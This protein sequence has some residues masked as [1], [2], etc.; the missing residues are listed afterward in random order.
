MT[1]SAR[2]VAVFGSQARLAEAVGTHQSTVA[3]WIKTGNIPGR[4]HK[5]ILDAAAIA[6]LGL[7]G[8]DLVTIAA[9]EAPMSSVPSAVCSADLSVG[10]DSAI[11]SIACY[12]LSDGRRVISRTS[13]LTA[14]AG[15]DDVTVGGDLTRYVKPVSS[16]LRLNLEDEL[17]EFRLDNVSNKA[18][19]G[20]TAD[21]FL[22]ICRAFVRARDADALETPR[23]H[24]IAIQAN[25]F[26][27]ACANVGLI[28]LIDEATGYQ[29]MRAEDA[30]RVKLRAY[31]EEQMRPWEKTFPDEL[32]I[33][34]G[35]LTNW[36]GSVQ[37]RPKYWGKLVNE[38][39]YEYLD[40]DVLTWLKENAPPPRKGQNY[41]QWL[42]SNFGL[43]KLVEHIW[44]LVGMA[45]AC[46][47][48]EELR[49]RM[50]ER[51]GKQPFQM[52]MFIDPPGNVK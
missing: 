17:I 30:L 31:L 41:H 15:G 26:L 18:V 27:S 1:A 14:I 7:S 46:Q 43:K 10:D 19:Y 20:I 11:Q 24:A 36:K 9:A 52:M 12:V 38:L 50:G 28:A 23:Q 3:H 49:F 2:A 4:W 42:T 32:W 8:A 25:A 39:V 45:A 33:E 37:Q 48:M 35:R 44:M 34:F 16:F 22:E 29:Y 40:P 21:S 13:A 5:K 47:T 51:F 6:G